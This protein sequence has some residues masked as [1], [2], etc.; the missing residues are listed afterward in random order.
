MNFV[1]AADEAFEG[2][3]VHAATIRFVTRLHHSLNRWDSSCWNPD[4]RPNC[5]MRC[6]VRSSKSIQNEGQ[7]GEGTQ[8]DLNQRFFSF[9]LPLKVQIHRTYLELNQ[10]I[11]LTMLQA[12][13]EHSGSNEVKVVVHE[14]FL[15]IH[16]VNQ[17]QGHNIP[18]VKPGLFCTPGFEPGAGLLL[19][20]FGLHYRCVQHL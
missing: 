9:N 2:S 10:D 14:I 13:M 12:L 6:R 16:Q 18:G 8:L 20:E 11:Q 17:F 15:D 7:R 1:Q 5:D 19:I 3:Y 4:R